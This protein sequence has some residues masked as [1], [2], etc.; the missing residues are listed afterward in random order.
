MKLQGLSVFFCLIAVPV[1]LVL[2]FYVQAQIN[3]IALQI[4]YDTKLLDA[5]HDAMV[6]LEINT[7]NE[8]LSAVS[9]SL[10]SIVNASANT[11]INSL[12][13]N[14]GMSNATKSSLQ[15]YIPSILVSL[16][17]GYYI[18]SPTRVPVICKNKNGVVVYV[19]DPGTRETGTGYT[20]DQDIV[21]AA[22]EA[23]TEDKPTITNGADYGMLMYLTD[24]TRNLDD[25]Q[26]EYITTINEDEV[27]FNT[28]YVLKAYIPY[29]ARYVND[30]NDIDVQINYTLDNFINIYGNIGSVYYTKSG[31]FTNI[32][33]ECT[34]HPELMTYS[35]EDI[36]KFCSDPNNDIS[37][38]VTID[39]STVN[40]STANKYDDGTGE[41]KENTDAREA[42]KYYIKSYVFSNW[43]RNN[44]GVLQEGDIEERLSERNME[45]YG[46][47]K[48]GMENQSIENN[49]IATFD[50]KTGLIFAKEKTVN[51][52]TVV[53]NPEDDESVFASHKR[54]V[55]KNSIQYNL[56]LAMSSYNEM[57]MS[58]FAFSMPVLDEAVWDTITSKV[59]IVAF[60]QGFKCGL[61]TY[62][63]YACVSSSNNEFTVIPDEIYFVGPP[64]P[65]S[66]VNKPGLDDT[67]TQYH[68]VNCPK[69]AEQLRNC[70]TDPKVLESDVSSFVSKEVKY[71]KIYDKINETYKYDHKNLA[72]Y[73]CIIANNYETTIGTGTEEDTGY[74]D[75]IEFTDLTDIQKK[76]YAIGLAKEREELYKSN[77]IS[78][79]EGVRVYNVPD[80]TSANKNGSSN[81]VDVTLTDD[82]KTLKDITSIELTISNIGTNRTATAEDPIPRYT[83]SVDFVEFVIEADDGSSYV[84]KNPE[85]PDD[86][87]YRMRNQ[88]AKQTFMLN[89]TYSDP[90]LSG[91]E[92]RIRR[93]RINIVPMSAGDT[94]DESITYTV[95]SVKINYKN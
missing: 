48:F 88:T 31:Y 36:D 24:D 30:A 63:N 66:L 60:M 74:H 16:Y 18:Y 58:S 59:S 20:Y 44:L 91:V 90:S 55:M 2:T 33:V 29:A 43:V 78:E 35:D 26:K 68:R 65:D 93:V 94:L 85:E 54:D 76:V 69:F 37:I 23:G 77:Q 14:L 73:T 47:S 49:I 75:D 7:A 6:A 19:G 22:I 4:S 50:G 39:G 56:N 15:P 9:D 62:S 12:S 67:F 13:T 27:A 80:G 28:D 3:T 92:K 82:T 86:G 95:N 8:D 51:G 57:N 70:S 21:D 17:D 71:D 32:D 42:I 87:Y 41:L 40:I 53:Q 25:N 64:N 46:T 10:R 1:I 38:N 11:F 83:R 34:S 89:F 84:I 61:K 52:N 45:A 72:C 5:T 79:N 81:Y